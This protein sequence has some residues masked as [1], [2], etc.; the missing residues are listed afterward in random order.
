MRSSFTALCLAGLGLIA[1]PC[2]IHGRAAASAP[3]P[4]LLD[5]LRSE[6]DREFPILK[7]KGDPA[8]YYLAYEVTADKVDSAAASLGALVS[9]IH[10]D[11]RGFDTTV[12][13][14]SPAFDN[15]HPAQ[16]Q[17][18]HFTRFVPISLTDDSNEIRRALWGE[19]D[20]VYTVGARRLLQLK[21]DQQLI[22]ED[23]QHDADFS[24]EPA[25]RFVKD[26]ETYSYD[27]RAWN[28]KLR[29]WSSLFGSHNAVLASAVDFRA[30]H[31]IRTFADTEGSAIQQGSNL[32]RIT[33]T[34][35]GV[36]P[37]GMNVTD[38]DS[39]EA[40]EPSHLPADAEI[41]RRVSAVATMVDNLQKA[42]PA[43]PIVAPAILS[44]RAS[45]VFFHEIFG[46]AIEGHRQKDVSE[47]QTFTNMI[48]Q[49]ILPSFISVRFDPTLHQYH[50]H[51]LIG[52]YDY[53]DEGVK[54]RPV[55]VV[56]DGVLKT[57]LMSRSPV[58][59]FTESNGHGR[60]Q[61]GFEVV[62][63]QSNLI[64]EASHQISAADLRASLI[65][66]I[67]RQNKPYGL[68]FQEVSSGYTT[69]ARRG[70]QAFSV[71]PLVVYRVYPDGR[72]DELIRGVDIVGT[73]LASLQKIIAASN[74][75]EMFNGYCGA[76]SG[77]IPVS[78]V[79]P[80]ILISEVE[81]QR[82]QN[83]QQKPPILQRPQQ[84]ASPEPK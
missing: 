38:Y 26:P 61:P 17:R 13:V 46:H 40:F 22:A 28:A 80:A 54:A 56:Q 12:R 67:K 83:A 72:P 76:E 2:L 3:A 49:K 37:D 23:H 59:Q 10:T 47:G 43:D 65:A 24:S 82:K 73:R 16:G 35:E 6:L 5:L 79:S 32:F 21:T 77:S 34:A 1:T 29:S 45:A 15:Y 84:E 41:A 33:I 55:T 18:P 20:S 52:Y 36:A 50:G 51:D 8:P 64:V 11:S 14:G 4:S 75:S 27:M 7:S 19:T 70:L 81:I 9:S 53:D 63:R 42:P 66:E 57:F 69:T 30:Q 71:V 60:R 74:E 25:S 68:Y 78:A 62:S 44:G 39:A 48:G 31:E 58:G